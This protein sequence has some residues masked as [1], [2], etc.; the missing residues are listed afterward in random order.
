MYVAPPKIPA[1][2]TKFE[3]MLYRKS[4][5]HPDVIDPKSRATYFETHEDSTVEDESHEETQQPLRY[6]ERLEALN[7]AN[8]VSWEWQELWHGGY[9]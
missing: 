2:V 5:L 4:G 9:Y 1:L 8:I 3:R 6:A 7:I